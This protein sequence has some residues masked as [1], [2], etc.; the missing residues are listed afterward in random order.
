MEAKYQMVRSNTISISE[1][2]ASVS[3]WPFAVSAPPSFRRVLTEEAANSIEGL[4]VMAREGSWRKVVETS[5]K[6]CEGRD[7][8]EVLPMITYRVLALMKLGQYGAAA[9]ELSAL[10][11]LDAS[12]L[13]H[14]AHTE[15]ADLGG[16][17]GVM[18]GGAPKGR[19]AGGIAGLV[20]TGTTAK[21]LGGA[22]VDS[23]LSAA[24]NAAATHFRAGSAVPFALR[25]L[26]AQLPHRLGQSS[27]SLDRLCELLAR[28]TR[29]VDSLAAVSLPAS[30]IVQHRTTFGEE[31]PAAPDPADLLWGFGAGVPVAPPPA[32]VARP[33]PPRTTTGGG[34]G[35][36][37][38]AP[39][40]APPPS[41]ELELW[42]MRQ[43]VL[44][45]SLVTL[46]L[47]LR[48]YSSA[49]R[50]VHWLLKRR[51]GAAS[52]LAPHLLAQAGYIQLLLG[53]IGGARKLFQVVKR[54][55]DRELA[56]VLS[57][58]T[59]PF[60]DGGSSR[61]GANTKPPPPAHVPRSSPA[62]LQAMVAMFEAL[63]QFAD[64]RFIEARNCFERALEHQPSSMAAV[65]NSSACGMQVCDVGTGIAGL[66]EC[67]RGQPL[68]G[69]H[70]ALVMNLSCMYELAAPAPAESKRALSAWIA[71]CAPDDFDLTCA[72]L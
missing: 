59:N 21:V 2:P 12:N 20:G 46:H 31:T 72:R 52:P 9:D 42:Q 56:S 30:E 70:E 6:L 11:D 64:G 27:L 28:T 50:W 61:R 17:E 33:S 18:G 54:L 55:V 67:L 36:A 19:E 5:R 53:E 51:G 14:E 40:A 15:L 29:K 35:A 62:E 49:L 13:H 71:R 23:L 63:L 38:G 68:L 4:Y 66:E 34:G 3:F 1:E 69:L 57:S 10:G 43:E 45:F 26:H 37:S 60:S 41:Y 65:V 32:P 39:P 16:I 48:Q 44:V 58:A 47:Q 25:L 22:G 24:S 7:A 8:Y